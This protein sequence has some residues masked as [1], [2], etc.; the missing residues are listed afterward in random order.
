MVKVKIGVNGFGHTGLLVTRAAFNSGK[1]DIVAINDPF[2]DLN[3]MAEYGK[4]IING[5][6]ITIF[7]E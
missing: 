4:L 2:T 5:N 1:V 7:Q 6:P 3:Y